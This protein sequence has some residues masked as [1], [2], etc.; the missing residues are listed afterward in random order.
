MTSMSL[1]SAWGKAGLVACLA[2]LVSLSSLCFGQQLTGTLTG[3]TMDTTGAVVANAKVTM[4]NQLNGDVRTTVSNSSGYFSITA[5]QPGTYTVSVEAAGFKQWKQVGIVFA[6]GDNRTLPQIALQVGAVNETVEI[7]AGALAVPTDNAEISTTVPE[8]MVDSFPMGNRDAGELLKI[9][10]G[11]AFANGS[12]QGS[13]FS[14]KVVGTNTGPIGSFS[15]NGTQPNGAMAFMLDGANLVDPGNAGTQI[16]NINQD[17]VQEVKV[18]LSDYSAEYAKGPV[19][20][21]AFSK[22]GGSHYH[23]EVYT[24]ARN[25]AL[26]AIDAYSHSQIASGA[27]TAA[28]AAPAESY[29]YIGGNFGGPVPGL[30]KGRQKLFFWG[31]YEY[32]RQ[33]PAGSIINY[34]VP[35]VEQLGGDFSNTTINGIPGSTP[36]STGNTLAQQLNNIWGYAYGSM[37][38]PPAGGSGTSLC[39]TPPCSTS[40]APYDPNGVIYASL[41]PA[42]NVTPSAGDG[43]NNYQYVSSV[44]QNRWEAT[45]KVDYAIGDNTKLTGSYTRQIETDQHPVGIWWTPPWTLPYPS[46]VQAATSSQEVMVNLTHVFSPT[47]TNEAV[48]TL[49][50]YINPNTLSNAKA[51][52]RATLGL[53]MT[54]LF[55]LTTKQMPNIL[56][57]WGGMFPDIAEMNLDGPF[58]GGGFG[59][60]KKD[61]SVYDNYTKVIGSHTIKLGAYWDTS[62]NLQSSSGFPNPPSGGANGSYALN[63]GGVSTGNTVADFLIGHI[64]QY[65]QPNSD[66]VSTIQNH[67]WAIYAQDSYKAN[68]QLTLSYGL[69]FDH[70]GQWYGP[71]NGMAV[72]NPA[73]YT[74]GTAQTCPLCTPS[75][76]GP[77]TTANTGLQWHANTP[78]IPLS[79]WKSP[80]FYY[81]PRVG[82]AYD[83][84]G[85]GKTVIRGG[86]ASFR[87]QVAVNDVGGPTN[88]A[89]GIFTANVYNLTSYDAINGIP[90]PASPSAN[91][92]PIS[93]FQ[94]GDSRTPYTNDW[95]LSIAQALPWRSVFEVSYVGNQSRNELLNGSNG[96]IDD[97]NSVQPGG[98][99]FPDPTTTKGPATTQYVNGSPIYVSPGNLTCNNT[100]NAQL[101]YVNCNNNG[102]NGVPL[103]VNYGTTFTDN[104]YR[105]LTNYQDI[106]L[107]THGSYAN[108][109]SL[110]A[111]WKKQSGP[112]SFLL[113][114]TYG[115][116]MGIRDGQ[117]DNGATNGVV[118]NPF[119]LHSNY[120]PLAYDHTQILN[121]TYV[122]NLPRFIHG[123]HILEGAINGW[124]LSG[125]TTRQSGQPLQANGIL[126]F[127]WA[128]GLTVPLAGAQDL[129]DNSIPLPNGLRSNQ[130]NAGTWYGTAQNGGGYENFIPQITCDPRHHAKGQYFNPNC[131]T[132][133]ALGQLGTFE[134]PYVHAPAYFDSDLGLYKTFKI[135]ESK[136]LQLRIQ[137]TNWLNH[138]LPQF[139]LAGTSDEN[140]NLTQHTTMTENNLAECQLLINSSATAP[141]QVPIVGIAPTN[142]NASTTGKPAF[143]IGQR[144][145]TFAAKFYF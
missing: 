72:W 134:W 34:N 27:T 125:Y 95:N 37:Y 81:E 78:G 52:D 21:Q 88:L 35:T 106:Y 142:T 19:I 145:V 98:Y 83:V 14:D 59:A 141:C 104:D 65:A 40:S 110:Q 138:P 128:S 3:T 4:T 61:P 89:S 48:F 92:T 15:A 119:D 43:W 93:A 70:E 108:Y 56:G 135:T 62:E 80:L 45:G 66:I 58:N 2:I 57:P 115:K 50:R 38:A 71:S 112:I 133:P 75:L 121:A 76:P 26:N 107:I 91:G 122:W 79:G 13:G 116:V 33:H 86:F 68:R 51:V 130:V 114:Y 9:M 99:F 42:A 31:G 136:Q 126:N 111:S 105:P 69:R 96:K 46:S 25:S 30:N 36:V 124:Q 143:K 101:N 8:H 82:V 127:T 11:M 132:T 97:L 28:L 77:I 140:I 7:S 129:P 73:T 49:A 54:G 29:Y 123:N 32:M 53:T 120:G 102:P 67:Q 60:T 84:F 39:A 118:V 55:G 85:N 139:G 74:N 20:F 64:N 1:Q 113:N 12:N 144:V 17:M 137:A 87:Y 44:P 41:L 100:A 90:A 24:Y 22:S 5:I 131:F 47:T 94:I 18:L 117:S 63:W 109:N 10:P 23:G 103:S 16:A 6:Q